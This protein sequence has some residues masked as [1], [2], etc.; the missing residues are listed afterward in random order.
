MLISCALMWHK[1]F[2]ESELLFKVCQGC[3]SSCLSLL[4][5]EGVIN[6][7]DSQNTTAAGLT[8]DIEKL[9]DS[10]QIVLI[11]MSTSFLASDDLYKNQMMRAINR[12]LSGEVVRVIPITVRYIAPGNSSIVPF[13]KIQG[14]PRNGK[15]IEKWQSTDE[16]WSEVAKEIRQVC[17]DLQKSTGKH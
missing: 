17:E 1:K 8:R 4:R 11:L 7:W 16:A 9:I 12:Q 10:S 14:L 5:R 2:L 13:Q 6:T 15:P 3:F